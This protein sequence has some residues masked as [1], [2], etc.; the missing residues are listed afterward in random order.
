MKV[1]ASILEHPVLSQALDFSTYERLAR[2]GALPLYTLYTLISV[3]SFTLLVIFQWRTQGDETNAM[4]FTSK[5]P[6]K[7]EDILTQYRMRPDLC[8]HSGCKSE[9]IFCR[10]LNLKIQPCPLCL[11]FWQQQ[12]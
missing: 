3:S 5:T 1:L 9:I 12:H 10:I 2:S 8:Y 11:V 7:S 4:K 6:D